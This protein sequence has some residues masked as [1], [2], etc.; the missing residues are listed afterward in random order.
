MGHASGVVV[1]LAI[2]LEKAREE[3]REV[4]KEHD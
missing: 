4:W 2:L 3:I 1:S